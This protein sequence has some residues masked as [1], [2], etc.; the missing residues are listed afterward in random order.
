MG[1]VYLYSFGKWRTLKNLR[2]IIEHATTL[3]DILF[4]LLLLLYFDLKTF[5]GL[6]VL[7]GYYES[8]TVL[9]WDHSAQVIGQKTAW[10]QSPGLGVGWGQA[11]VVLS[12]AGGILLPA[13]P[14]EQQRG[15]TGMWT[16][17]R[18]LQR[19]CSRFM[20]HCSKGTLFSNMEWKWLKGCTCCS[21]EA[22]LE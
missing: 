18:T 21:W 2:E 1:I 6:K 14:Q 15:H 19:S 9:E 13:H 16:S 7:C 5:L 17:G 4:P 8:S 10:F 11:E 22:A 12:P 3:E 20:H